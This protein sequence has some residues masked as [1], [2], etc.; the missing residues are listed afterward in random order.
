M[1]WLCRE[2]F[3][4]T[5][6]WVAS[7]MPKALAAS[8][9][10][11]RL[12]NSS[13]RQSQSWSTMSATPVCIHQETTGA[14]R[15]TASVKIESNFVEKA[16]H[17]PALFVY[18]EHN[19]KKRNCRRGKTARYAFSHQEPRSQRNRRVRRTSGDGYRKWIARFRNCRPA[20]RRGEGVPR[21][22]ACRDQERGIHLSRRT[23]YR[24]SSSRG[25]AKEGAVYDL[26]VALSILAA[27]GQLGAHTTPAFVTFGELGLDGGVRPIAGVLPMVID[28]F[29]KGETIFA[30]PEGNAE[31]AAYVEGIQV[32]P[33]STLAQ[34]CD[35]VRGSAEI[36]PH[37]TERWQG[38]EQ[39]YGTDFSEIKGQQGA[40]RAAEI[41]VAGGH[42]IL[43][44][45]TP[46]RARPCLRV[47]FLLSCRS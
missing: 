19:R 5:N 6:E 37:P 17:K 18:T 29:S 32:L 21:A 12:R 38:Y 9:K 1:I 34:L 10:G 2:V 33:V 25:Y 26:P 35:H 30:V 28:A 39:R 16:P 23:D 11:T 36:T 15:A 46:A 14:E 13:Q 41:A 43:L 42:N 8:S 27:S 31:E 3:G 20:G 22:R 7:W 47:R 44:I 4:V 45:G 40:K 24:Q